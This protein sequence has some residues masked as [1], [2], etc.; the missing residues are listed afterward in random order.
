MRTDKD[1]ISPARVE[2]DEREIFSPERIRA[3]VVERV[4]ATELKTEPTPY[5]FVTDIFPADYYREIQ[6]H[7]PPAEIFQE[8]SDKRMVNPLSRAYRKFISLGNDIELLDA[9]SR[10]CWIAMRETLD[11]PDFTRVIFEKFA[12]PMRKRYG[13]DNLDV[14]LRLEVYR[15]HTGYAIGPHTDSPSKAF[16]GLFYLP[17][18]DSQKDL[19]T[20]LFVP[21]RRGLV[22]ETG[23]Q[24]SFAAFDEYVRMPFVPNAMFMFMKTATSFHGRY[25]IPEIAETR[26]WMNCSIQLADRF[27]E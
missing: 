14:K 17:R 25:E 5:I 11:H 13:R 10:T 26:N 3:N 2:T 1:R 23:H 15:D 21:K 20:S 16:T 12:E 7:F 22:E 8:Q 18:D 4:R 6:K 24:M 9:A 27:F 19:G